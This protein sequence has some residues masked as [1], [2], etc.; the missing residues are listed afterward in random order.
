M[1]ISLQEHNGGVIID[2]PPHNM[3]ARLLSKQTIH[4]PDISDVSIPM[5]N[6]SQVWCVNFEPE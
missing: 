5:Y 6:F 4:Y 3:T 2:K 1:V